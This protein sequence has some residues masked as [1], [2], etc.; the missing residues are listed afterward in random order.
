M[1]PRFISFSAV[2]NAANVDSAKRRPPSLRPLLSLVE[3][4]FSLTSFRALDGS[5]MVSLN[6]P[7]K[8]I[9]IVRLRTDSDDLIGQN[10]C[11]SAFLG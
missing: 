8:C 5:E 3:C 6:P 9:V 10:R 1:S 7:E 11:G 2:S 4:S